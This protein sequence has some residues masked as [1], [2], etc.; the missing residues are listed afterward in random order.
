MLDRVQPKPLL[1]EI[2]SWNSHTG[3]AT[4]KVE[5][6]EALAKYQDEYPKV[7]PKRVDDLE[8]I[9]ALGG[10]WRFRENSPV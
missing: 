4:G 10:T 9:R 3:T 5:G 6:G 2:W 8:R 7:P 1:K